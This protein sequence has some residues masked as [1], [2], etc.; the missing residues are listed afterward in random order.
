VSIDII[1]QPLRNR[2]S[3]PGLAHRLATLCVCARAGLEHTP[4]A[5]MSDLALS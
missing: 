4:V 2:E 5:R 3:N 1:A